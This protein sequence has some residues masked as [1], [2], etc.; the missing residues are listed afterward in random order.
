MSF[1]QILPEFNLTLQI[2]ASDVNGTVSSA[3]CVVSIKVTVIPC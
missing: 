3:E 1:R 2:L